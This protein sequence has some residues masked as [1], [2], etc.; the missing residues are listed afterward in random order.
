MQRFPLLFLLILFLFT[1]TSAKIININIDSAY[2][3]G[4]FI[5]EDIEYDSDY[6]E[7]DTVIFSNGTVITFFKNH[8]SGG[9]GLEARG[10]LC[11]IDSSSVLTFEGEGDENKE[12]WWFDDWCWMNNN[13][14]CTNWYKADTLPESTFVAD[15]VRLWDNDTLSEPHQAFYFFDAWGPEGG[16]QFD[17]ESEGLMDNYKAISYIKASNNSNMKLQIYDCDKN[18]EK[19]GPDEELCQ[20][21]YNFK[22][23]W[24]VDSAGNGKFK[25]RFDDTFTESYDLE[26][27]LVSTNT[28]ELE[29][30]S[31]HIPYDI[32]T[33][34]EIVEMPA[35]NKSV[36]STV[37][38][39]D[40]N[41]IKYK[42][43][44][45]DFSFDV[46]VDSVSYVVSTWNTTDSCAKKYYVTSFFST[47]LYT[48]NI[49][50]PSI[51]SHSLNDVIHKEIK[52]FDIHGRVVKT[53]H[54]TNL[55]TI[56]SQ[57][58]SSGFYILAFD[59]D[60]KRYQK[61]FCVK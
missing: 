2:S 27:N 18:M 42:I 15:S 50:H 43:E 49:I 41:Y 54:N 20:F 6:Y 39:I 11:I 44:F 53:L 52:I 9:M 38:V 7:S 40:T 34:V 8:V 46:Y 28:A 32:V 1:L 35:L 57:G 60:G 61:K 29:F 22:F 59:V 25:H 23:R 16:A 24:T 3:S 10:G 37:Y 12:I 13:K 19:V 33:N 51:K 47:E 4:E 56:N 5:I 26:C 36:K 21:I 55:S 31:H 48:A 30:L 45:L 14:I 17:D 58:L